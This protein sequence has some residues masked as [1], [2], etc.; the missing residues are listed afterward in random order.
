[1]TRDSVV[2][3][4]HV[5]LM[6]QAWL[7]SSRELM[8]APSR[9]PQPAALLLL[10]LSI[11]SCGVEAAVSLPSGYRLPN[12]TGRETTASL[13]CRH[14]LTDSGRR[15]RRLRWQAF[16]ANRLSDDDPSDICSAYAACNCSDTPTTNAP[17]CG[18]DTA[19]YGNECVAQCANVLIVSDGACPV[20]NVKVGSTSSHQH[21]AL[22]LTLR[23]HAVTE[24]MQCA[25]GLTTTT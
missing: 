21:P 10:V 13:I 8:V 16:A 9:R 14:V 1:M 23:R 5:H 17:V 3:C 18:S 7:Q 2:P 19:T 11:G 22:S 15:K 25:D 20:C 12:P 6:M 24:G 4:S